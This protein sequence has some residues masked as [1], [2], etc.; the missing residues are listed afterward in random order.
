MVMINHSAKEVIA[1]LVYYGPGLSGK[2][3][4]LQYI[5]DHIDENRR[6][7]M[8]SASTEG[9]RTL[10]F[11]LL[12]IA[13]GT[14]QG[15]QT[16][17]QLYTVPGQVRYD[18]IRKVVLTGADAVVFVADSQREQLK[19]NKDSL[20]NLRENL[21]EQGFN[22]DEMLWIIQYNKRDLP[23]ILPVNV[24]QHELNPTSVPSIEACAK[25]GTNVLAALKLISK[26]LIK[27]FNDEGFEGGSKVRRKIQKKQPEPQFSAPPMGEIVPESIDLAPPSSTEP[28]TAYPVPGAGEVDVEIS[29]SFFDSSPAPAPPQPPP[30]V[31]K[32]EP[33]KEPEED[34]SLHLQTSKPDYKKRT[35]VSQTLDAATGEIMDVIEKYGLEMD[36]IWYVIAKINNMYID[37]R[38]RRHLER[39]KMILDSGGGQIFVLR[40]EDEFE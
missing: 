25:D 16:K 35:D 14:I 40:S 39:A 24:L 1:K 38:I 28:A 5:Y 4:N 19:E 6:G 20:K 15:F 29:S 9:D 22:L 10:F 17:F 23:N 2:T 32:P 8:V 30:P 31:V 33:E 18:K 7:K 37:M 27:R 12:P 26:M 34:D 3:T 21:A 36:D 11:D 13:L